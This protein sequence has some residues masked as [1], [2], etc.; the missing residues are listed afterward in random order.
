MRIKP[1]QRVVRCDN[2]P[3]P[4]RGQRSRPRRPARCE[5]GKILERRPHRRFASFEDA[6]DAWKRRLR[7]ARSRSPR[8]RRR[9]QRTEKRHQVRIEHFRSS[10]AIENENDR[11][12]MPRWLKRARLTGTRVFVF[13]RERK[14]CREQQNQ[15]HQTKCECTLIRHTTVVPSNVAPRCHSAGNVIH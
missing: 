8:K 4:E 13:R 10:R 12:E 15:R 14:N 6:L 3:R 1:V 9:S 2:E 7:R 11:A 5:R